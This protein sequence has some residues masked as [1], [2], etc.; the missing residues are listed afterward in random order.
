MAMKS[1]HLVVAGAISAA[2]AMLVQSAYAHHSFAMFDASKTYVFTGVV[3]GISPDSNHLHVF[4]AP[5]NEE[6]TEVVRGADGEPLRWSVE[7]DP[8][9]VA[10]RYGLTA[11]SFPRGTVFSIGMH[12]LR[13]GEPG[14]GRGKNGLFKCPADVV[15]APGKHCD[16]VPGATSHG[17]D[18]LPA[19][20]ESPIHLGAAR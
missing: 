11:D 15:P 4:F 12:P 3:L 1:K 13:T 2:L 18:V 14:G 7:M 20:A 16:S 5:L 6:R 17:S 19:G 9:S 10:A 8:A